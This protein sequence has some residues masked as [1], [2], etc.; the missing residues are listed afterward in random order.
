MSLLLLL[1]PG[2]TEVP[3]PPPGG[4]G[5]IAAPRRHAEPLPPFP[6]WI[7][8]SLEGRGRLAGTITYLTRPDDDEAIIAAAW[9]ILEAARQ[10]ET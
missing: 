10:Q 4:G 3:A 9:L 6:A 8:A 1:R 5:V 7:A 2:G